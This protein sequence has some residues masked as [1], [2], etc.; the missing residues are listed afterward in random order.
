[1][2]SRTFE[3][4]MVPGGI[5]LSI[6]LSQYD[7]DVTLIFQLYA[8]EGTLD[9][10]QSG[11]AIDED[12]A[13]E[14]ADYLISQIRDYEIDLPLVMDYEFTGGSAGRLYQANQHLSRDDKTAICNAFC[15]EAEKRGYEAMI[16]AN[17]TML[18]NHLN[19]DAIGRLWLAHYARS[20]YYTDPYEFWQFTSS[21]SIPGISGAVDL[22]FWFDPG[23]VKPTKR[24]PFTD[25]ATGDWF[26][27]SVRTAFESG[28][29]TGTS[30]TTFSP[31]E[32]LSRGQLVTMLYRMAGSPKVSGS[33]SFEDLTQDYYRD[34]VR[35]ASKAGY[36]TGYSDTEFGPSDAITRQ[37]AAVVLYRMAG[38]P[39]VNGKIEDYENYKDVKEISEYARNA[40][41]WAVNEGI[42]QGSDG[43][44]Y[45]KNNASRAEACTILI[46]FLKLMY[47]VE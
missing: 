39:K 1:M 9:I 43:R 47:E 6:H 24:M 3:L 31:G 40:L 17:P 30:D 8:S 5:P 29:V 21:G 11:Q 23:G 38:S 14:E 33:T 18:Y 7:S 22:D 10:P 19:T 27:V 15:D 36:V 28:L 42:L 34:P 2:L 20:T 45:P 25:V 32:T 37:D 35:W 44:L 12:E 4:D 41:L 13:R 46:R 16:Y 26:Y